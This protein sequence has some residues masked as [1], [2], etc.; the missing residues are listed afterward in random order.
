[1]GLRGSREKSLE[2]GH[3]SGVTITVLKMVPHLL[4]PR[5]DDIES[6]GH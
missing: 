4:A 1:M 5:W 3:S 6:E 2:L